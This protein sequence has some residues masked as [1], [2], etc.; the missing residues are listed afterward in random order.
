MPTTYAHDLFGKR[1]YRKLSAK[2]QH[3]IRSNGNLYRIGQHG[4][5]ILFYYFQKSGD[6]VR[7]ADARTESKR[8]L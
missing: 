1:V 2:L 6:T 8:I 4:P 3:L 7:S 5:D